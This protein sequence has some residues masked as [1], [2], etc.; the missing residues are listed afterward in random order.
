[1]AVVV[2][3]K[4]LVWTSLCRTVVF[5]STIFLLE[6][7]AVFVTTDVYVVLVVSCLSVQ[8]IRRAGHVL[9]RYPASS[10]P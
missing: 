4:V 8:V 1:M 9:Y 10:Q 6:G 7:V 2:V 5:V 3:E